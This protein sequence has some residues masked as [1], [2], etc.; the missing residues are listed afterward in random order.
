MLTSADNIGSCVKSDVILRRAS[1]PSKD[2]TTPWATDAVEKIATLSKLEKKSVAVPAAAAVGPVRTFENS[3]AFQ[4]RVTRE[5]WNRV[6][7]GRLNTVHQVIPATGLTRCALCG[8]TAA[9]A[10]SDIRASSPSCPK[11]S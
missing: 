11:S 7:K 5:M 3:P 9:L 10:V 6:L 8:T 4:R 1:S 2:P